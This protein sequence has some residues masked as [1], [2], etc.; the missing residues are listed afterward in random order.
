MRFRVL[1]LLL[2]IWST[3]C[4]PSGSG[5][6]STTTSPVDGATLVFIPAGDFSMGSADSDMDADQD[7]RPPHTIYLDGFWIDRTEVTN[8]M[9]R[10]C[11]EA[12]ACSQPAHS[13]RYGSSGYEDHPVLGISWDQAVEYCKWAGRRLPTEAEWEKAARGTDGRIYPWGDEPP[14]ETRLNFDHLVD[15]TARIASY[16]SG[17]S[18]YGVMDMAGNVWEWVAD[19]YDPDYYAES[20]RVNPQGGTS[21]NRRVLRGGSWST[22]AHN[23]RAANRFWGFPGRNDTDGFRCAQTHR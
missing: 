8:H 17:A 10:Q 14:D 9:Y 1:S 2:L 21:V 19:S 13:R 16:H 15:D 22:A 12:G 7:E 6:G 20:P 5:S 11:V 3:A 18:P 4:Q 23:V